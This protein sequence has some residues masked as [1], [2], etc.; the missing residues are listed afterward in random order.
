MFKNI[1]ATFCS[2]QA[3][4]NIPEYVKGNI[5]PANNL[6]ILEII[7][8]ATPPVTNPPSLLCTE[9]LFSRNTSM[10]QDVV[11]A[12]ILLGLHVPNLHDI[13]MLKVK[14]HEAKQKGYISFIYPAS[15][16]VT[17]QLPF[18]VLEYWEAI[19]QV[20]SSKA[21][22]KTAVQWIRSKGELRVL[23]HL[24]QL[25]WKDTLDLRRKNQSIED[26]AILCSE[27]WLA[28]K[29]MDLFGKVLEDQLHSEGITLASIMET[30]TL[31]KLVTM[32]RHE[33][34]IYTEKKSAS[35]IRKLGEALA[36]GIHTKIAMSVS[37]RVEEGRA[38]LP[39]DSNPGNHWVTV[40]LDVE[41]LSILYGDSYKLP[42]PV[43]LCDILHWWLTHHRAKV[44]QWGDLPC[45]L[46]SDQ[47]SCPIFSANA[48][49]HAL[50]P[51]LFPLMPEDGCISARMD[52]LIQIV[53]YW[54]RTN[55][56][57]NTT[58]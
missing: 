21:L 15:T 18:W 40:I 24:E 31:D 50:L 41:M 44:F 52:M 46:Q 19:H 36:N 5:L 6:N 29:H 13:E 12:R 3:M 16:A 48:M 49:A 25:P 1:R 4:E 22:W 32:Y 39:T 43:E 27:K 9:E 57:S 58:I 38:V 26:I 17:I 56:V 55:S 51:T 11:A 34:T 20:I 14:T 30:S 33:P 47:F 35:H 42:P 37:V 10:V 45:S 2:R 23:S 7:S 8:F 28:S 53:S 54:K